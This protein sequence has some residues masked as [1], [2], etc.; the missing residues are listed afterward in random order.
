MF[1]FAHVLWSFGRT[2]DIVVSQN[3]SGG[4]IAP[5]ENVCYRGLQW[6]WMTNVRFIYRICHLK[7]IKILLA[8]LLEQSG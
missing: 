3:Q 4:E 8:C 2:Q 1:V 7:A 5:V 6:Y